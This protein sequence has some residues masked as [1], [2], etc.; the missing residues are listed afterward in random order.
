[1]FVGCSAKKNE[2]TRACEPTVASNATPTHTR[3]NALQFLIAHEG[4]VQDL[5]GSARSPIQGAVAA[6]VLP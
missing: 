4:V 3:S 2:A 5:A 6:N 1:M